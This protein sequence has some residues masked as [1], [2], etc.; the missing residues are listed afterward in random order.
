MADYKLIPF[1]T[2]EDP[3][4]GLARNNMS[5]FWEIPG[6]NIIWP[7]GKDLEYLVNATTKR[8]PHALLTDR[9]VRRHQK[10]IYVP[11]GEIVGYARW[12]ISD[13]LKDEWLEAQVPDVS[14]EEKKRFSEQHAGTDFSFRRDLPDM[15]GHI[16]GWKAKYGPKGP[17]F[18][19]S[20]TLATVSVFELFSADKK[21]SRLSGMSS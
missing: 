1:C 19:K 16:P 12:V 17:V 20:T 21:R 4:N 2:V 3:A 8:M 14:E 6:W 11:T 5:A 13:S 7:A 9:P 18:G 15:D 10:V